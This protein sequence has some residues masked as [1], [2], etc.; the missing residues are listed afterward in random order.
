MNFSKGKRVIDSSIRIEAQKFPLDQYSKMFR[1]R[2]IEMLASAKRGHV[3]PSFSICEIISVIF[4]HY[5]KLDSILSN[6]MNRHRFVL[7]KG[8]GCLSLYVALAKIGVVKD[9]EL[10]TFCKFDSRL[11]GHPEAR[12]IPEVEFSTG[13]LGHGLSLASG[14]ALGLRLKGSNGRVFVL[15]GDGECNEGSIWE[16]A[17]HIVKHKLNN[18][19][20]LVDYNG[21]QANGS[22]SDVLD[23]SNLDIVWESI[24]FNVTQINGH[25]KVLIEKTLATLDQSKPN[26]IIAH[27]IKGKGAKQVEN[28]PDWHHKSKIS[29][30]DLDVLKDE[31]V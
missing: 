25:D 27:T 24:G 26:V 1:L 22:S 14:L 8:H 20:I 13:A 18:L 3:G 16:A 19:I 9:E 29:D 21:H 7:S 4:D 31:L 15:I 28:N 6:D 17:F 10:N 12:L 2:I 11:G 5:I 30:T 23:S